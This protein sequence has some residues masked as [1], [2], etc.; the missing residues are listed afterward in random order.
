MDL[1]G[2]TVL[3]TGSNGGIGSALVKR[4]KDCRLIL[5]DKGEDINYEIASTYFMCDFTNRDELI[6]VVSKIKDQFLKIDILIN[7]AGIG[8]YKPFDE[9]TIEDFDESF[10][11]NVNAPFLFIK[12]LKDNLDKS[13]IKT[14]INIGSFVGVE[15][16]VNRSIYCSTKY[17]LR[18]MSLVLSKELTT[19]NISYFRLGSVLTSFGSLEIKDKEKL[20]EQG[21]K[22]LKPEEVADTIYTNIENNTL[23][24]EIVLDK[25]RGE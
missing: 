10:Q 18:G 13:N 1:V 23:K 15:P 25:Q 22:Y 21:K 19:F 24:P 8:I 5:V 9:T 3:I 17:A 11:I 14:V 2:K 7:N 16:V 20:E 12:M 4:F 6:E